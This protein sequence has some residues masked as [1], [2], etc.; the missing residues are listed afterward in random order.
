MIMEYIATRVRSTLMRIVY[1]MPD[2]KQF[3]DYTKSSLGSTSQKVN[4]L[5]LFF[6]KYLLG[7]KLIN[8][9][10]NLIISYADYITETKFEKKMIPE[11]IEIEKNLKPLT[12]EN[13]K[14]CETLWYLNERGCCYLKKRN[15]IKTKKRQ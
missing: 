3:K 7:K 2:W 11:I 12:E 4:F 10:D 13:I 15:I 9:F 8:V 6:S 1:D 5:R 14:F